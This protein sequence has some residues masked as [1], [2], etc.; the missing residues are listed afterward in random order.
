MYHPPD[1]SPLML[2]LIIWLRECL[3]GFSMRKLLL[4]PLYCTVLFEGNSYVQPHLRSGQLCF[5]FGRVSTKSIWKTSALESFLFCP[6]YLFSQ[7]VIY[8]HMSAGRFVLDFGLKSNTI[9]NLFIY[10]FTQIVPALDT[11]ST[12][13]CLLHPVDI[14]LFLFV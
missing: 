2:T 9:F 8:I 3:S 11:G 13:I 6:H 10:L 12:F 5:T 14:P 7:S 4:F 1:L